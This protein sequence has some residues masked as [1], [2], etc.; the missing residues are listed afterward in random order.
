[1][2]ITDLTSVA[3]ELVF[4]HV[5]GNKIKSLEAWKKYLPFLAVNR[6]WREAALPQ[7]YSFGI[8]S[9][10]VKDSETLVNTNIELII[11]NGGRQ[12][13]G[14]LRI[15]STHTITLELI[16]AETNKLLSPVTS[17][18]WP[19]IRTIAID[20]PENANITSAVPTPAA[21]SAMLNSLPNI[22]DIYIDHPHYQDA[23]TIGICSKIVNYYK[24]QLT[25]I[26]TN[27]E[28][29]FLE[30]HPIPQLT[31]IDLLLG[32]QAANQ[33]PY[34]CADSL[35]ILRLYCIPHTMSW[36]YFQMDMT[37]DVILFNNL[38]SLNLVFN[39]DAIKRYSTVWTDQHMNTR[40]LYNFYCPKLKKVMLKDCPPCFSLSQPDTCA[41]L[42]Q[43]IFCGSISA[44]VNC[45]G[46]NFDATT[47]LSVD[48]LG[49][50]LFGDMKKFYKVTN[51]IFSSCI[52][53]KK[54]CMALN[55][56]KFGTN[57]SKVRWE[58]LTNLE[59]KP[60]IIF[61]LLM[62]LI[63]RLPN[64]ITLAVRDVQLII[65]SNIGLL[66]LRNE[67]QQILEKP[68]DSKIESLLLDS[69]NGTSDGMYRVFQTML[70]QIKSLKK[71]QVPEVLIETA[72]KCKE[73]M[74]YQYSHS[75]DVEIQTWK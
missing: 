42:T 53:A 9:F 64:L 30:S 75:A 26:Y 67:L 17:L 69:K 2:V 21:V 41:T 33:L 15:T 3:L 7:L 10:V 61:K 19:G 37:S 38:E 22:A 46:L 28:V 27:I 68:L 58:L 6:V 70:I 48:I 60:S 49:T 62:D 29:Y 34:M 20:C 66:S 1:M 5:I 4:R 52:E 43:F 71:L 32:S 59:I 57:F 18:Q 65:S 31:S 72:N 73:N 74:P 12:L 63:Y 39:E 40:R 47:T 16:V 36:R 50:D 54:S 35:R 14:G 45:G 55:W 56:L 44:L 13:I 24:H 8:I 23:K 11:S 51:R 25:N